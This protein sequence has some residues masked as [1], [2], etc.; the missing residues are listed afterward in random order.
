MSKQL[1]NCKVCGEEIAKGAKTCPKC[2]AKRKSSKGFLI[3]AI[4]FCLIVI[5][6]VSSNNDE[7]KKVNNNS[8]ATEQVDNNNKTE[9][10]TSD[11]DNNVFYVGED[12]EM[13]DIIVSLKDVSESHGSTFNKP[14]DGNV[15]VICEFEITNNSDKEINISSMLSFE[16]YCDDYACTFSLSAL[17]EKQ[18]KNQLDG[19]VAPGKKFNGIVGYEVPSDWKNMEI[20]FTPDFWSNKDFIFVAEK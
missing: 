9:E 10:K 2:G 1:T 13:N 3:G 7:P 17:L 5:A 19:T 16:A 18:N 15:F 6:A 12:A 14:A 8:Q 4:I 11:D 20:H